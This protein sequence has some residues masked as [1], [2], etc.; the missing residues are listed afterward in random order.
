[1][2]EDEKRPRGGL[3][4]VEDNE[5]D[6]LFFR[7]A[8]ARV[9]PDV[10]IEVVTNGV[11]AMERLAGPAPSLLLLDLKLPRLSGLEILE[12]MKTQPSLAGVRKV[13]LT[14]SAEDSDI[15]RA[16]ALGAAAFVV[17]PVEFAMLRD[18]VAAILDFWADP[19]E[20]A[21]AGLLRHA[22]PAPAMP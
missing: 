17:K 13:V 4:L 14:S 12:W 21:L 1:M 18:V 7:R 10:P 22:V 11:S 20:A 19:G 8:L 2:S 3:L 15:R 16:Y 5:A 9:K 6:I